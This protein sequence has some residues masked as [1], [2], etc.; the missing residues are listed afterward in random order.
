[1]CLT[2]CVSQN[3]QNIT[4]NKKIK[5]FFFEWFE[6]KV[7]IL[8]SRAVINDQ[9]YVIFFG[10]PCIY[11]VYFTFL[12]FCEY[13]VKLLYILN[14]MS[15]V[16]S[17][18]WKWKL[19]CKTKTNSLYNLFKVCPGRS[20]QSMQEHYKKQIVPHYL[21]S[22]DVSVRDMKLLLNKLVLLFLAI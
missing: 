11:T 6:V 22:L 4:S 17:C 15:L 1:M 9:N 8:K 16:I 12:W 14:E 19:L 20:H 3:C 5:T 10:T 18:R 2:R 21:T 7:C 13:I